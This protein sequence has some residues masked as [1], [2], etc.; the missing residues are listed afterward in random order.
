MFKRKNK[1]FCEE[2][3]ISFFNYAKERIPPEVQN[4]WN[5]FDY[6]VSYYPNQLVSYCPNQYSFLVISPLTNQ[7][8]GRLTES[9]DDWL[10]YIL[11]SDG[12]LKERR[13]QS[14]YLRSLKLKVFL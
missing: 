2:D 1:F 9:T 3:K 11:Q 14:L 5:K 10:Y 4:I 6:L 7:P 13:D 12:T 8:E